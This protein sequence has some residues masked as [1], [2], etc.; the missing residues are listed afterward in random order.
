MHNVS[1]QRGLN[2]IGGALG[3]LRRDGVCLLGARRQGYVYGAFGTR[4]TG[5]AGDLV[6][7]E[8]SRWAG[9]RI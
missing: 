2:V 9:V 1:V 7:D 8:G 3:V 6:G 5:V 4:V